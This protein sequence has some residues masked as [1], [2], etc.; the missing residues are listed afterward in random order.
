MSLLIVRLLLAS[1]LFL[2]TLLAGT[3]PV[4][5]YRSQIKRKYRKQRQHLTNNDNN[6]A[7]DDN[8]SESS[9]K[10]FSFADNYCVQLVTQLGGGVLFFTVMAHMI[11]EVRTNFD[12]YLTSNHSIF[13]ANSDGRPNG[14]PFLDLIICF[15]FFLIFSTDV[16]MDYIIGCPDCI[17]DKATPKSS[18]GLNSLPTDTDK[19]RPSVQCNK[20]LD[21]KQ[22]RVSV[23]IHPTNVLNTGSNNQSL[24]E[25]FW[26]R[27]VHGV[28]IVLTFSVHCLFDGIAIGVQTDASKMWTVFLAITSHKLV[29]ALTISVELYEIC[30][31]IGLLVLHI[32]LFAA[33]S[34]TGLLLV[35][36]VAEGSLDSTIETSL[37]VIVFSALSSGSVLYIVFFELLQKHRVCKLAPIVQLMAMAS[38][39]VIMFIINSLTLQ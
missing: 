25:P 27:L 21:H 15:G 22:Q 1:I 35:I 28:V 2:V 9:E 16:L 24:T 17:V 36:I 23:R 37:T 6:T 34:P 20:Q 8:D 18:I 33:L 11:P 3:V 13:G 30:R 4:I 38:G 12:V 32:T 39:F 7:I 31:T 29:I 10:L 14:L 19:N 26:R 5:W